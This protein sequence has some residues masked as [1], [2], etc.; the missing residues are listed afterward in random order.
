MDITSSLVATTALELTED[1]TILSGP[2][3]QG[4]SLP[5]S[6]MLAIDTAM[7]F[8]I[9]DMLHSMSSADILQMQA[10]FRAEQT[11]LQ[12]RSGDSEGDNRPYKVHEGVAHIPFMGVMSKK[13]TCMGS[14][15]GGGAYSTTLRNQLRLADRDP[16]VN[17]KLLVIDSPGG[18]VSGAFDAGHDVS[19]GKK[20]TDV[21][22]EDMATSGAIVVGVGARNAF[23]NHN[24]VSGSVGVFTSIPDRSKAME[25]D[26]IKLHVVKAGR[27][28]AIGA[29]GKE[30]TEEEIAQ[31]Q[32]RVDQMHSLFIQR[33]LAGRPSLTKAQLADISDAT[34]Y[35]G[36]QAKKIGLIDDITTLDKAHQ[37]AVESN[38]QGKRRVTMAVT[39]AQL[40]AWV[41]GETLQ[42]EETPPVVITTT[43]PPPNTEVTY[44][45][46]QDPLLV[47]LKNI[48]VQ[49]ESDLKTLAKEALAGRKAT[50]ELRQRALRLAVSIYKDE[51][52]QS[53]I[54]LES[55][56][57]FLAEAPVEILQATV[58]QYEAQLIKM[59]LAASTDPTVPRV[60]ASQLTSVA[61]DAPVPGTEKVGDF[62]GKYVA[63]TYGEP[64]TNGKGK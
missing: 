42:V 26:G 13:P 4:L 30:V 29:H 63:K 55:A 17:S 43:T 57:K 20:P 53:A 59:G 10:S 48:G 50:T 27:Y 61:I 32:G 52:P 62:A 40:H 51:T 47:A 8:Y 44:V 34:V 18:D 22:Y 31:I 7:L 5:F 14:M 45:Q 2:P 25:R 60:S 12:A 41:T 37:R 9:L 36:Q 15:M 58:I 6:G 19:H 24:A 16:E 11:T 46:V 3:S 35:V 38:S 28:K 39:D 1:W 21:F 49:S 56:E 54:I 64:A 33:V 23:A